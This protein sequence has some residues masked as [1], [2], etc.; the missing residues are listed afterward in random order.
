MPSVARDQQRREMLQGLGVIRFERNRR[1][2]EVNA[3]GGIPR[4]VGCQRFL[5]QAARFARRQIVPSIMDN[6]SASVKTRNEFVRTLPWLLTASDT[7][8]IVSSSGASASTM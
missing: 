2:R 5:E 6:V 1:T 7:R 3:A 8:V 4:G